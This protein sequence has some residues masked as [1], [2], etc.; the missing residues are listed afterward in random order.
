MLTLA[1]LR[2]L[3]GAP[4]SIL[5]AMLIA[6]QPV[7][8]NW[9]CSITGYSQNTVR[10]G[11][12]FL[13]ETQMIRRN[14]RYNGYVLAKGSIQLPLGMEEISKS[15]LRGER[16]SKSGLQPKMTLPSVTTTTA[17]NRNEKEINEEN[18]VEVVERVSKNDTRLVLL[19]SA[20][21]MEPTASRLLENDW[22]TQEYL[23]A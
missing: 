9:L 7:G 6:K 19:Y 20:G 15:A 14:E 8:E 1:T 18:A 16:H 11:C 21:V 13:E 23:E 10:R 22:V 2:A 3:K 12:K 17:F 4:L 5:I